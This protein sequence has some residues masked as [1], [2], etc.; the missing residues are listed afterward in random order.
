MFRIYHLSLGKYIGHWCTWVPAH[1]IHAKKSVILKK[2]KQLR[3][4]SEIKDD[5]VLYLYKIHHG[6]TFL[7][8]W[9]KETDLKRPI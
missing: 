1:P 5:H 2:V 8:S 6:M 4:I 7:V 9:V 3:I